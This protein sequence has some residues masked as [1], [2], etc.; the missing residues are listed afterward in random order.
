MMCESD[1]CEIQN[2]G[3]GNKIVRFKITEKEYPVVFPPND[4]IW[5]AAHAQGDAGADARFCRL[6]GMRREGVEYY[7]TENRNYT[8]IVIPVFEVG[9]LRGL[10]FTSEKLKDVVAQKPS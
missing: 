4:E 6:L 5:K 1:K 9:R 3:N 2:S 8:A 10:G 7:L